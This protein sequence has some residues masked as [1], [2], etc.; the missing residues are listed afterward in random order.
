[1]TYDNETVVG[2]GGGGGGGA[3]TTIR[4]VYRMCSKMYCTKQIFKIKV[5]GYCVK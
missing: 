5:M 3:G 1:M 4:G 2:G